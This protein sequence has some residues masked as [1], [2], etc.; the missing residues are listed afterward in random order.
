[1]DRDLRPLLRKGW[2]TPAFGALLRAFRA[3]LGRVA[4]SCVAGVSAAS[5]CVGVCYD[6]SL[7]PG[8]REKAAFCTSCCD[9]L[10]LPRRRAVEA[11]GVG[12][13]AHRGRVVALR[14]ENMAHDRWREV[15]ALGSQLSAISYQLSAVS[16]ELPGRGAGRDG[17][18]DAESLASGSTSAA[19]RGLGTDRAGRRVRD[20]DPSP[21]AARV[22]CADLCHLGSGRPA[23]PSGHHRCRI[24]T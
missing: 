18:R 11:D 10:T 22:R 24:G 5:P 12:N 9:G 21:A 20:H 14:R 17:R 2:G 3:V 1:M 13:S 15:S 4:R 19:R 7:R 8:S 6:R 16:H 23:L